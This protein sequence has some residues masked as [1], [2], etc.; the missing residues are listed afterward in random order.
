MQ[1]QMSTVLKTEGGEEFNH[2][3]EPLDM[4]TVVVEALKFV[5]PQIP[6]QPPE[7]PTLEEST[8]RGIFI[9]QAKREDTLELKDDDVKLIKNLVAKF[10]GIVVITQASRL[11]DGEEQL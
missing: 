2:L 10:W 6:G 5:P 8:E 7:T 9:F 3:G 1:L 4:R 11:L